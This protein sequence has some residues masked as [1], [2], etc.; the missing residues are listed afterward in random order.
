MQHTKFHLQD[1][2]RSFVSQILAFIEA[3][4]S[5]SGP[6]NQHN[7]FILVINATKYFGPIYN[8]IRLL[9]NAIFGNFL[10]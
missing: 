7:F 6:L 9:A 4:L 2:A 3:K 8:Y 10:V 1:P 5:I